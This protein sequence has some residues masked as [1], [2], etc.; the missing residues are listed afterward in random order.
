MEG[1]GTCDQCGTVVSRGW[2]RITHLP[3][4]EPGAASYRMV[5]G[6][7]GSLCL[8]FSLSKMLVDSLP[9]HHAQI[10]RANAWNRDTTERWQ[11]RGPR[12]ASFAGG[13]RNGPAT[14]EGSLAV[15][16]K[17]EHSRAIRSAVTLPGGYPNERETYV[18]T[19]SRPRTCAATSL[20]AAEPGRQPRCPSAGD[21]INCDP[22]GRGPLFSATR[23][24]ARRPRNDAEG[25]WAHVAERKS[26]AWKGRVLHDLAEK[27]E[28][29]GQ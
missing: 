3:G 8:S 1:P 17:A 12:E 14:L 4:L 5:L 29:W 13:V 23:K 20:R 21:G 25:T 27:A 24:R 22:P 28:P 11:G 6:K 18:H 19:K 15:S 26:P 10:G 9:R 16:R 2:Q 7:S